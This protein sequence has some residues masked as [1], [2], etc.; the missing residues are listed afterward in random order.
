MPW[1]RAFAAQPA[2]KLGTSSPSARFRVKASAVTMYQPSGVQGCQIFV[3]DDQGVTTLVAARILKAREPQRSTSVWERPR[4]VV[5]GF[6]RSV[7]QT[8]DTR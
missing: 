7:W 6:N 2:H 1:D 5:F 4:I 8:F 3:V